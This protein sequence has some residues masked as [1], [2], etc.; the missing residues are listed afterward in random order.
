M[1]QLF[2]VMEVITITSYWDF[3]SWRC[4]FKEDFTEEHFLN[5][6]YPSHLPTILVLF[7]GLEHKMLFFN[8]R[9]YHNPELLLTG[10]ALLHSAIS[11]ENLHATVFSIYGTPVTCICS[12][13][14]LVYGV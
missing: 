11:L 7:T 13:T 12:K 4:D 14:S 9:I 10:F 8:L 3:L 5:N 1:T 6:A 2:I